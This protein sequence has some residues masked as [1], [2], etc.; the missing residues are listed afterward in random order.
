MKTIYQKLIYTLIISLLFSF[1]ACS[2]PQHISPKTAL[3]QTGETLAQQNENIQLGV[4]LLEVPVNLVPDNRGEFM[5]G[6]DMGIGLNNY[7]DLT[8]DLC[9]SE[10]SASVKSGLKFAYNK[11][12]YLT[13]SAYPA[14]VYSPGSWDNTIAHTAELNFMITSRLVNWFAIYG[15]GRLFHDWINYENTLIDIRDTNTNEMTHPI[16][17]IQLNRAG[18]SLGTE[19]LNI[20][21]VE[22]GLH[23]LPHKNSD[24]ITD[25]SYGEPYRKTQHAFGIGVKFK[26]QIFKRK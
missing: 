17:A 2:T 11:S 20:L 18:F 3:L 6:F 21:Y 22:W 14:Y 23:Y 25:L 4:T 13:L 12:Q 19:I 9:V 10:N 8:V 26:T 15:A 7:T 24:I 16:K 5:V 1:S